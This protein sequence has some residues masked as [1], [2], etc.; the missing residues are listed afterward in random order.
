MDKKG[1]V[2]VQKTLDPQSLAR[3][4]LSE[5][6]EL[7]GGYDKPT[8]EDIAKDYSSLPNFLNLN[9][10]YLAIAITIVRRYNL[11]RGKAP[12]KN[13]FEHLE[14][15]SHINV[16]TGFKEVVLSYVCL[17]IGYYPEMGLEPAE[18]I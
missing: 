2:R 11:S 18:K 10:K 7:F 12:P 16:S 5:Q 8:R 13:L 17:V 15:G 9:M 3:K 14:L 4:K 1:R 6:L